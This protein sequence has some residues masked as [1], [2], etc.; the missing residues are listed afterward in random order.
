MHIIEQEFVDS[1][2]DEEMFKD[3]QIIIVEPENSGSAVI[4]KLGYMIQEH[5]N[6]Y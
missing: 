1:K 3:V 5:G 2:I 6:T 4:D